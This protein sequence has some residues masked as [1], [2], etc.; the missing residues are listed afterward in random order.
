MEDQIMH[1]YIVK[2]KE[3]TNVSEIKEFIEKNGGKLLTKEEALFEKKFRKA[4]REYKEMKEKHGQ[5]SH[6]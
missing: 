6:H 3:K 1:T 2:V 4:L 5:N